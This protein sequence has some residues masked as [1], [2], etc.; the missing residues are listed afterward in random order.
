MKPVSGAGDAAASPDSPLPDA[1]FPETTGRPPRPIAAAEAGVAALPIPPQRIH[2]QTLLRG[3]AEIEIEHR[4]QVYR[5]R[6]TALGKLIL[7]K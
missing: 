6:Q 3:A 2:S 4:A 7:T 5:L 1:V